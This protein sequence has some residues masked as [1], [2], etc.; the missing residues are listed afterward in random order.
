MPFQ[1]MLPFSIHIQDGIP[2]SDQILRAVRKAVLTGQMAA[3]DGFPSVRV[4]SQE[5]KI[6]PTTA[7]KVVSQLKSAGYIAS[8]PGIGMVVSPPELPARGERLDLLAPA[9]RELFDE[10][11]E[12]G[13]GLDDVIEALRQAG[14]EFP[15]PGPDTNQD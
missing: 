5:L 8:R 12:I 14:N 11:Q 7:H 13:L 9:C 3:G 15:N 6:S 1:V 10:A 4:M 2:V